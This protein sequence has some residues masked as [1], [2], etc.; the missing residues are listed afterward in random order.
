MEIKVVGGMMIIIL[1]LHKG[2]LGR[3]V[4]VVKN[5]AMKNGLGI[6]IRFDAPSTIPDTLIDFDRIRRRD[7]GKFL[8]YQVDASS[9]FQFRLGYTP[10]HSSEE[11]YPRASRPLAIPQPQLVP[12]W[13]SADDEAK[14]MELL[15]VNEL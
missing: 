12:A 3:V 11:M 6:V 2:A 4:D 14:Q 5:S 15:L 8:T 10:T 13:K 7:N 1:K 9:Y